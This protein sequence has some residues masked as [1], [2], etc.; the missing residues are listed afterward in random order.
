[1]AK[2]R[3][4]WA[5]LI[6]NTELAEWGRTE[7]RKALMPELRKRACTSRASATRSSRLFLRRDTRSRT[8]ILRHGAD[9]KREVKN[10]GR[11]CLCI[12]N[13]E[14][15][16]VMAENM[17]GFLK[18][19]PRSKSSTSGPTTRVPGVCAR[20]ARRSRVSRRTSAD[21]TRRPRGPTCGS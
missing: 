13:A 5:H 14:V 7:V 2:N 17:S 12:S 16:R 4:N 3:F 6:T 19:I 9:G 21:P 11:G 20:S 18:R 10:D 1:M 15:G 8:R